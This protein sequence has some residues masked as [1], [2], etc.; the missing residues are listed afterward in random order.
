MADLVVENP[1]PTGE[2]EW[3]RT[4]VAGRPASYGVAG[5]GPVVVFLHGWG[6]SHRAYRKALQRL[7]DAHMCVY[8]PALPGFGSADLPADERDLPGYA[9]WVDQFLSAVWPDEPVTLVGHSFGGG[10]AIQTAYDW[11]ARV[12]RLV[13]INSIGGSAWSHGGVVRSIRERPLWDWGLHMQADVLPL[14]QISRVL[15]V[16]AADAVP[17]MLRHPGAI[18]RVAR[19][20]RLADLTGEL[21]ELKRR[22]LPVV[23]LWGRSDTVIPYASLEAL[24]AALGDPEVITVPGTHTWLLA[25]PDSFGEVMTNVLGAAALGDAQPAL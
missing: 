14:R 5:T 4:T 10:V 20:A 21:E 22:R 18:V 6:L 25:D 9:R 13:I 17:N 19:L 3:V 23:I 16:I 15:P 1:T 7:I 24:R 12:A 2:L 11:P 8:A